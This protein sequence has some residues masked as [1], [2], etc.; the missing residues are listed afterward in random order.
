MVVALYQKLLQ[1]FFLILISRIYLQKFYLGDSGTGPGSIYL[2][3]FLRRLDLG[4][5]ASVQD[6]LFF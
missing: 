3:V 1:K 4:I 2:K 6:F 5:I